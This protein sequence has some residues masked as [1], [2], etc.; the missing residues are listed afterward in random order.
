MKLIPYMDLKVPMCSRSSEST[1]FIASHDVDIFRPDLC[2]AECIRD[3]WAC[4]IMLICKLNDVLEM[5][6]N[7]LFNI[8]LHGHCLCVCLI[9]REHTVYLA[10]IQNFFE[11]H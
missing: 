1:V 3:L 5:S 10:R 6:S 7:V 9:Q 8:S 4:F 2:C 11:I